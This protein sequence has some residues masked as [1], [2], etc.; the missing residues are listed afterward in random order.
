[1]RP[2]VVFDLDGTIA[3]DSHRLPLILDQKPPDWPGYF[4]ACR[5]DSPI[6]PVMKLVELFA[7]DLRYRVEIWTGRS[8]TVLDDTEWWL[9]HHMVEYDRLR[10]RPVGDYRSNV[11]LKAGWLSEYPRPPLV[12]FD[13]QWKTALWW[14]S[15]QITC[16]Q[17]VGD[18]YPIQLV[19]AA[20]GTYRVHLAEEVMVT[21]PQ[22]ATRA[23]QGAD[24]GQELRMAEQRIMAEPEPCIYRDCDGDAHSMSLS[25]V[26]VGRPQLYLEVF[27]C[28]DHDRPDAPPVWMRTERDDYRTGLTRRLL[29][30]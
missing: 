11:D 20:K 5:K 6:V 23:T 10:M 14:H 19:D 15:R 1:M 25:L 22:I 24:V 2:Y 21:S 28:D 29:G 3:D 4:A 9:D 17:V 27:I 26:A 8:A 18:E 7:V 13:D 30:V 16:L 12:V